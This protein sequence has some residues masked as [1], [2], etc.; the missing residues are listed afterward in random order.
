MNLQELKTCLQKRP[1]LN[2]AV[3]LPDGRHVP[4][5]YHVTEVGHVAKKFVD[6]GG[7]F[8]AAEACVLQTYVG[9]SKDDGH[10]LTA[11]KLVQILGFA[12]AFLPSDA[13]PVEVEYEDQVVSQYRVA[14][15]GL[16]GD[17][18]DPAAGLQAYR[19]SRQGEMRH[20]RRLRLRIRTR[21]SDRLL[22]RPGRQPGVLLISSRRRRR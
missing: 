10:R 19:L 14:G 2:L 12:D 20:R 21:R 5:H 7:T 13:L 18:P 6:C 9:S 22:H 17:A 16:V 8:R 1:E 4:A 11:G 3:A 15:A